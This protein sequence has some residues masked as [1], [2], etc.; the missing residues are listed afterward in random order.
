MMGK[1]VASHGDVLLRSSFM[2]LTRAGQAALFYAR[3]P[4][5]APEMLM[6]TLPSVLDPLLTVSQSLLTLRLKLHTEDCNGQSTTAIIML[7][8]EYSPVLFILSHAP[9]GFIAL[10]CAD[11]PK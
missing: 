11:F 9:G 6:E 8:L 3:S 2:G 4:T 10:C 5:S 1:V 7:G